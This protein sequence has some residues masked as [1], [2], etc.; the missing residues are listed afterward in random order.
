[1]VNIPTDL[2][3]GAVGVLIFIVNIGLNKVNLWGEVMDDRV[4]Q[5]LLIVISGIVIPGSIPVIIGIYKTTH[6]KTLFRR[7]DDLQENK[8]DKSDFN[9]A[10]IA[11]SRHELKIAEN[12]GRF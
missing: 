3:A 6:I 2:I 5:V 11:A 4:F 7:I 12:F 1:V 10:G 9:A 8:A